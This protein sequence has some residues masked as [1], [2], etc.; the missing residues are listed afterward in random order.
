MDDLR[1]FRALGLVAAAA[2]G[3]VFAASW[4]AAEEGRGLDLADLRSAV[5]V[6]ATVF[7]ALVLL[8]DGRSPFESRPARRSPSELFDRFSP[9]ARAAVAAAQQA[10]LALDHNYLGTEHLLLGILADGAS[11]TSR[12]VEARG[13]TIELGQAWLEERVGRGSEPVTAPLGL[14]RRSRCAIEDAI[15]A[16]DRSGDQAID[17][18]HLLLA[19]TRIEDGMAARML[20]DSGIALPELRREVEQPANP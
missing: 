9:S 18:R 15:S 14:T 17:E 12:L 11:S 16:A 3:T 7:A 13:L 8:N 10:A 20:V 19:L 2:L 4:R 6:G 1:P 5:F